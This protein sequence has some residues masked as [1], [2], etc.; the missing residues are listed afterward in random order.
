MGAWGWGGGGAW[1]VGVGWTHRD[2]CG[3]R[4]ESSTQLGRLRAQPLLEGP[5]RLLRLPQPRAQLRSLLARRSAPSKR[6]V[7][8]LDLRAQLGRLLAARRR[9]AL[10]RR[11]RLRRFDGRPPRLIERARRSL[12]LRLVRLLDLRIVPVVPASRSCVGDMRRGHASGPCVRV[13]CMRRGH[14]LGH[15]L[16]RGVHWGHGHG[17]IVAVWTLRS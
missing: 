7:R 10:R 1:G 16:W 4:L 15:A 6:C 5:R 2:E 12:E 14:A 8:A 17:E 9:L 11:A 13:M 3:L